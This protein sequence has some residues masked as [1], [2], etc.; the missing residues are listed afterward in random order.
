MDIGFLQLCDSGKLQ[1]MDLVPVSVSVRIALNSIDVFVWME[2]MTWP[3]EGRSTSFFAKNAPP[4]EQHHADVQSASARL[5]NTSLQ[6][7]DK[8]RVIFGKIVLV[9]HLRVWLG[10]VEAVFPYSAS[11]EILFPTGQLAE[12]VAVIE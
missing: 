4:L 12:P 5:T 11:H 7:P 2:R 3:W 9:A 10:T 6:S 8:G 1:R